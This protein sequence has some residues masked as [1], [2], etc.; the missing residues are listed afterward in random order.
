MC[1][2]IHFNSIYFVYFSV[3]SSLILSL[4]ESKGFRSWWTCSIKCWIGLK[5]S[6][7]TLDGGEV[8]QPKNAVKTGN[9]GVRDQI[10]GS[11][12]KPVWVVIGLL[13]WKCYRISSKDWPEWNQWCR[14]REEKEEEVAIPSP[15]ISGTMKFG[16]S[17]FLSRI[18]MFCQSRC[19]QVEAYLICPFSFYPMS[20]LTEEVHVCFILPLCCRAFTESQC[21]GG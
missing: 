19:L 21:G 4:A 5:A 10:I 9:F 13:K 11:W 7:W 14:R 17:V 12:R 1:F 8:A 2:G 16:S 18:L 15:F 20:C 6:Q 3:L